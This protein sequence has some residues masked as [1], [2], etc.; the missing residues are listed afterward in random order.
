MGIALVG[1]IVFPTA[2]PRLMP[3]WGFTDSV[4]Q[5]T[6]VDA[7]IGAGNALFNPFAAVPSMHVAFSLMIGC[8]M[9]ADGPPPLGSRSLW[10]LLS[11]R[12][13]VRRR[14][15]RQPLVVRRVPRRGHRRP[16]SAPGRR[17]LLARARPDGVGL[18]AARRGRPAASRPG[19]SRVAHARPSS[20]RG[21]RPTHARE[22][23]ALVRNRLIESR[24]TP[25]AIS[26]T[27][28]ALCVV[29]AVLVWQELLLPR[30]G[31]VHRRL[32]LRHARRP[33][34]AHVGQGHAVRRVPGLDAR[35]HGGGHRADRRRRATSRARGDDLA[36]AAVVARRPGVADGVLHPRPRRGAGRRVQGR[37]RRPRRCAS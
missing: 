21:G 26:L 36:V 10:A 25:N 15:D 20:R 31:R 3:E 7:D 23:Q 13:H 2:P 16:S 28:F 27:G 35:P 1:Y 32:G 18:A 19:L 11:A 33:L 34:L 4:A 9:V 37:D 29:A 6:G 12:G 8:A 14:R 30:R 24:L 17:A 5:F 22:Y